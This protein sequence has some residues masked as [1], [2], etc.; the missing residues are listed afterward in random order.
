MISTANLVLF[1]SLVYGI[2]GSSCPAS[3]PLS[4]Y[5]E[6]LHNATEE[7]ITGIQAIVLQSG[8]ITNI[9]SSQE[10]PPNVTTLYTALTATLNVTPTENGLDEFSDAFDVI[11]DAYFKACYGPEEEKPSQ[12]DAQS[13]LSDFVSLLENRSDITRMRQLFGELSC[14][15]NF[16]H[17][18][19]SS[20]VSKREATGL[21]ASCAKTDNVDELY[22]MLDANKQPD[23]TTETVSVTSFTVYE[24]TDPQPGNWMVC[25]SSG[26]VEISVTSPVSLELDIDYLEESESGDTHIFTLASPQLS[27]ISLA[28][29][30]YLEIIDN[31]NNVLQYAEVSECTSG[32][33]LSGSIT[34]PSGSVQYQLRGHDIGGIPFT[35]AVP[36]SFVNFD[37]PSI[38]A[39]LKEKSTI[40]LNPGGTSLVYI[41]I[42]NIK[43]GPMT[44][45]ASVSVVIQSEVSVDMDDTL[46]TIEPM[47][48]ETE[49]QVSFIVPETLAVDQ[50]LPWSLL[51][52]DECSNKSMILNFTA[53]VK[54]S[55]TFNVT[56]TSRS[57]ILFEWSPP[58]NP[59]LGNITHYVLTLDFNNGTIATVNVSGDI[60]QYQVNELS[61][62]QQVYASIVAHSD[63]GETAEIAPIAVLTDQAEPGPVSQLATESISETSV[64]ISWSLPQEQNG[65]ILF[66]EVSIMGL[67]NETHNSSVYNIK[68]DDLNPYT[69]YTAVVSAATSAGKGQPI[70]LEFYSL[71]GKPGPVSQLATESISE[72]SVLISWSLPQ[73]Q[74]GIIL[75]YEVSIMGLYNETHNSSVYEIKID[76]LNPYTSYT[77]V[78]SA[79][80]S[81][82]KGQAITLEFYSLEGKPGPVSQLATE[83]I[84]ETSVLISWSLP[85]EQNGIILFY[86]V[87]IMGLYNETHNSSVYNIKID[88][89]NPYTSYTAVVSAAT[90]AGKGQAITLEFY[91]LEG[92]PGPVSQL[93]TESISE[94]SVLISWSLPQEQ[95]GIILFYEVS[96]MGLYNE[97]HNSSVYN[98]KIDDLSPY[99]SYT[100][101]VSAATSAGKGQP[102]T[103]EFYSLEGKPGPVSQLATESISETSVLI[104]WSLPQ[105]QNGIILF[106]EVSIMG[107]YNETHNSSV[108]SINVHNLN[109]YTRYTA[110]VS[111]ATSAGK[112]QPTMLEF[113]SLE[114]VP[115]RSP[116]LTN[117]TIL[118]SESVIL[119]W[120]P[121]PVQHRR[122]FIQNYMVKVQYKQKLDI[123]NISETFLYISGLP[124]YSDIN[125]LASISSSVGQGPFSRPYLIHIFTGV[126]SAPQNFTATAT[127]SSSVLLEWANPESPNG[128]ILYYQL[129]FS[130]DNDTY[131]VLNFTIYENSYHFQDLDSREYYFIVNA[132]NYAGTGDNSSEIYVSLSTSTAKPSANVAAVVVPSVLVICLVILILVVIAVVAFIYFKRGK[133]KKSIVLPYMKENYNFEHDEENGQRENKEMKKKEDHFEEEVELN[134]KD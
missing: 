63:N 72:T 28:Y 22:E 77:A 31:F 40:V 66:Y 99:T 49:I 70:T 68:I 80:T 88:D 33:F 83:S 62:Y 42:S 95:N 81:A 45:E 18:S 102:I 16:N 69:S 120:N 26:A 25:V 43:S 36:D 127:S 108:N 117:H 11:T 35:H 48:Q 98:I 55:I 24:S 14:L 44:L 46:F 76:D 9:T 15:Q 13:I 112:G 17:T 109:P 6:K 116:S 91:S 87:S 134:E 125:V 7:I 126:A 37:T 4:S 115:N 85:Q 32:G 100:A 89:L 39:E 56:S 131:Q 97:T 110:V 78:V 34:L 94:T 79:A 3:S 21:L 27:N 104:S 93:T 106:Y 101:V 90:S 67:Y 133:G 123:Y 121:P 20:H 30:L 86:E 130:N 57:M 96:I 47:R 73:E 129:Y 124:K 29:P 50:I 8:A 64:L 53:I 10:G 58:V 84:S 75:F 113:Y 74:N 82:G 132:I 41:A 71:E 65:I 5:V 61:P 19:T 114:G 12:S 128:K 1:L 118:T 23:N 2:L 59:I 119:E 103:L 122:G 92:K 52:V 111:A 105:E 60:N 51:I 107:L 38:E 54:P